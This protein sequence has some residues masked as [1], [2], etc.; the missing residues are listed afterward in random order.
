MTEIKA[1]QI[2]KNK[3]TH[4]PRLISEVP[5]IHG[6]IWKNHYGNIEYRGTE[7]VLNNYQLISSDEEHFLVMLKYFA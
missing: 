7:H 2:W 5:D 3:F 1:G 4:V 6:I